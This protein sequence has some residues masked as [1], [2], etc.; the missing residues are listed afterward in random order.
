MNVKN[1]PCVLTIAGSD[2][3]GG[4]GIQAD[5]KTISALGC[6]AASV[7]TALT[8]QNTQSVRAIFEVSADFVK[9]QI[10]A[11][12]DDIPIKAV[13]IGMLYNQ[14]IIDVVIAAL[15]KYKPRDVVIDPVM[16]AKSGDHLL[17]P[18]TVSHLKKHLFPLTSLITPNI[19]EA[20]SLLNIKITHQKDMEEAVKLLS[21]QTKTNVLLKGG[22]FTTENSSDVLFQYKKQTLEW[23]DSPRIKTRN[24]HGTGCTLSSAIAAYL[25]LDYSISEAIKFAKIYLTHAIQ[26]GSLLQLGHGHGPVDHFF[27]GVMQ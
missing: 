8:A 3:S 13:K 20:E 22:H 25:A 19:P 9:Q 2:S 4:A 12:F 5:I 23:F 24:T 26:S 10:E 15:K 11:V 7:I 16:I 27:R 17:Q 6:Y 1:Y 14:S 18:N 21:H